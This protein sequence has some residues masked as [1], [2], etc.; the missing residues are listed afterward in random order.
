M[1]GELARRLARLTVTLLAVTFACFA[2]MNLIGDPLVNILGNAALDPVGYGDE[3][4][5]VT[6]EYH[7]DDPLPVR[8]GLWLGDAVTGDLGRSYINDRSVSSVI[9][10]KLPVTLTLVLMAQLLAL[11]IAVPWGVFAASRDGA[12]RDRGST[13][14]SFALVSFPEFA[15]GVVLF[16]LLVVRWQWFPSRFDDASFGAQ[17]FSLLAPAI[18]MAVPLGAAYQRI[19]HTELRTVL[20]SDY[21]AYARAKGLP[22]RHVLVHHALRPSSFGMLTSFGVNT[23]ALIGG[24][25]VIE[26]IFSVPGAGSEIVR[27]IDRDDF[28]TVL[29]FVVV[30]TVGFVVANWVVDAMYGVLDPRTRRR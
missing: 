1:A 23:G 7:L 26:Q 6:A 8:Y 11:V 27:A 15:L 3:I 20:R 17:A 5:E 4:A 21:I 2:A 16:Y 19:L 30:I 22:S 29:G 28:P 9:A 24:A 14:A 13:V 10:E 12:L 25:L 18:T